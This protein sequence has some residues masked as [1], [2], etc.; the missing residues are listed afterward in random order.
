ML[1]YINNKF[2]NSS[3]KNKVELY[4]LPL[5][6]I[7]L[8]YYFSSSL[9]VVEK[10]FVVKNKINLE[11]YKNKKFQGSFLDFFSNI[12][13][14][15]KQNNIQ[16][17]SLNNKKNIVELKI[18][19][20]KEKLPLFIKQIEN[21]NKFTKITFI[22]MYDK[23]DSNKYL[24]DLKIDLNKF[25]IKRIEKEK[26]ISQKILPKPEEIK[27]KKIE[28]SKDNYELK[29]IIAEYVLVNDIWLKQGEDINGFKVDEI[30]RNSIVLQN[31]NN[32]KKIRLEL[33]DEEYLEN[34][35]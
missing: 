25:Y 28:I 10:P 13:D 5:M 35:Y 9:F 20:P 32:D 27:T 3:L 24:F 34:I 29:A 1:T 31:I 6:I 19:S 26:I 7:Y 18:Q 23:K 15:A 30:K 21:I 12:E 33:A 17:L 11:E 16:I 2:V 14:N 4:F 22:T 8:L